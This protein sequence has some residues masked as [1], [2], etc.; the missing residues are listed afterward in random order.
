MAKDLAS[1]KINDELYAY[2]DKIFSGATLPAASTITSA[3]FLL[4]KTLDALEIVGAAVT[5]MTVLTNVQYEYSENSDMSSSTTIDIPFSGATPAAG[6][7]FFRFVPDHTLPVYAR[8]I[9]TGGASATGT[10][11]VNI[12]SVRKA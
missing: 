8:V 6:A 1:N 9:L 3:I 12:A 11:D 5:S 7:E 2:N 10:F 4:G